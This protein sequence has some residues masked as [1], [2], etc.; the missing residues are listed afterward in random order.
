[1]LLKP[2]YK[3]LSRS[4]IYSLNGL[5]FFCLWF[6]YGL[7][8]GVV[9]RWPDLVFILL[10]AVP[11]LAFLFFIFALEREKASLVSAATSTSPIVSVSLGFFV[12][13]EEL[14][15]SQSLLIAGIILALFLLALSETKKGRTSISSYVFFIGCSLFFG[16]ANFLSKV[17]IDRT[18]PIVFSLINGAWMVVFGLAWLYFS[19]FLS[20]PRWRVVLSPQGGRGVFGDMVYGAGGF[21]LFL[22]L[23]EGPVSLVVPVSNLSVPLTMVLARFFL[24]EELSNKQVGLIFSAAVLSSL[25]III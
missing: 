1:M 3:K 15:P 23:A 10:P 17:V 25:L 19:G 2:A 9:W 21:F 7:L 12:L 13:G 5:S 8:S 4:Q 6:F 18:G 14:T 16:I 11:P 20:P 22:A 24:G